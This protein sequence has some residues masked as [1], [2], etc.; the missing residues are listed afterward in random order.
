[1]RDV[2]D[3]FLVLEGSL[4]VGWEDAG[5]KVE[6]EL[7]PR[8]LVKTP[9]GRRHWFRNNGAGAATVWYVVGSEKPE[10]VVFEKA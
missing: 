4:T 5:E 3:A 2:E 8:D 6:I 7:G 9:A 1:V 10:T